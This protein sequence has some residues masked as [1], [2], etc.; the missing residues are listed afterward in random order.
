M[1]TKTFTPQQKLERGQTPSAADIL[2]LLKDPNS[3]VAKLYND[4]LLV[5]AIK[6]SD[7]VHLVHIVMLEHKLAAQNMATH[8]LLR[9]ERAQARESKY[10]AEV[11]SEQQTT[12]RQQLEKLEH[13]ESER[14]PVLDQLLQSLKQDMTGLLAQ[15]QHNMTKT[16]LA[17]HHKQITANFN[18]Q[19]AAMLGPTIAMPVK[20]NNVVQNIVLAVPQMTSKPVASVT[21]ILKH[22]PA[23]PHTRHFAAHATLGGMGYLAV[24]NKYREMLEH[25][26]ERLK[27]AGIDVDDIQPTPQALKKIDTEVNIFLNENS[28]LLM[29]L[30]ENNLRAMG[31]FETAAKLPTLFATRPVMTAGSSRD[32]DEEENA[33]RNI[34]KR[35]IKLA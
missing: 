22:S 9:A 14:N 3:W 24:L 15:P 34:H 28:Q 16:Q 30:L 26:R 32:K 33:V 20:V 11:Y 18:N 2:V 1:A 4:C 6:H 23:A 19:V 25:N 27:A 10:Y 35:D 8:E 31:K 29:H 21:D 7:F 5:A 13:R 17:A 12:T